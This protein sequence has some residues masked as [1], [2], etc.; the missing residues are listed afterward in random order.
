M[1]QRISRAKQS[2]KTTGIPFGLPPASERAER[3][4]VVLQVL[5]LDLQRGLHDELRADPQ[6]ADL[7]AEAI[8]LTRLLHRLLPDE[9]RSPA[10]SR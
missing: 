6:R 10:C 3:L 9:A 5:Y 7:T 4:R 1:A 2:I 8:R